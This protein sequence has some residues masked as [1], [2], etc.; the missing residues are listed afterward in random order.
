MARVM[1][2]R[3]FLQCSLF[4]AALAG[5]VLNGSSA[6]SEDDGASK[7]VAGYIVRKRAGTETCAS[8]IS[9][10]Y[11]NR[12]TLVEGPVSP[13]GWCTYYSN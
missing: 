11:P 5:V 3:S 1:H 13:L 7:K 9:F 6:A 8:C 2:R 10:V 12:C 4:G